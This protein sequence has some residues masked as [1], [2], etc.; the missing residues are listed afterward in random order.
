MGHI[1]E[2]HMDISEEDQKE[3]ESILAQ[4]NRAPEYEPWAIRGTRLKLF[5]EDFIGV[6]NKYPVEAKQIAHDWFIAGIDNEFHELSIQ[7]RLD[8][9]HNVFPEKEKITVEIQTEWS[10]Y[11]FDMYFRHHQVPESLTVKTWQE[12]KAGWQ[13][14]SA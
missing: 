3:L 13:L 1:R 2:I 10:A 6:L 8:Y 5:A 14:H 11:R 12:L 4:Y 7:D 9:Y